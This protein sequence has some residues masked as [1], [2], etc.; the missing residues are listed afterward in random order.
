MPLD[1][2][3]YPL[4]RLRADGRRRSDLRQLSA[5]LSTQP[6]SSDGSSYLELGNTK[7]LC[8]VHGPREGRGTVSGVQVRDSKDAV[9]ECEVYVAAF[10]E[11]GGRRRRGGRGDKYVLPCWLYG[12]E[13][14]DMLMARE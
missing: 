12:G 8:T 10:A 9:V 4:T 2:S 13:G 11:G 1:S 5:Q 3:L 7:V 14:Y 6:A